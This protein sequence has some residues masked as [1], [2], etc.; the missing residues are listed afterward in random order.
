MN[1]ASVVRNNKSRLLMAYMVLI[2]YM[3][4][5]PF[6]RIINDQ[7]TYVIFTGITLAVFVLFSNRLV[8][9]TQG[10]YFACVLLYMTIVCLINRDGSLS[11][12]I[13][14]AM[15]LFN[16]VLI[17]CIFDFKSFIK[18]YIDILLLISFISLIFWGI[19]QFNP[20]IVELF[21]QT[22]ATTGGQDRVVNGYV[23]V[24]IKQFYNP[25][26]SAY[27]RNLGIFHEP[28]VFA[29][30]LI[31]TLLLITESGYKAD[32]KNYLLLFVTVFTTGSSTAYICFVI[33]LIL[34]CNRIYK[35]CYESYMGKKSFY[36]FFLFGVAIAALVVV[37]GTDLIGNVFERSSS[38]ADDQFNAAYILTRIS[39]DM[40]SPYFEGIHAVLGHG[41]GWYANSRLLLYN[42][43]VWIYLIFG[44]VG[45]L[46]AILTYFYVFYNNFNTY[47]RFMIVFFILLFTETVIIYPVFLSIIFFNMNAWNYDE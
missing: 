36:Q 11:S 1:N 41:F 20:G 15:R 29:V 26:N 7:I 13:H 43:W 23:Y 16:G 27:W 33:F 10:I 17:T 3:S 46:A 22:Q 47:I 34:Y 2:I 35:Y 38:K 8:Y 28:G 18:K 42:S 40:I 45:S 12:Y 30:H 24:F 6:I 9:K 39:F 5:N 14:F 19:Y 4:G 31:F 37:Q 44:S 21:P 32:L 25:T